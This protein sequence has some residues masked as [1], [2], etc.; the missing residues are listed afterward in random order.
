MRDLAKKWQLHKRVV[1]SGAQIITIL[2]LVLGV[3]GNHYSN[4]ANTDAISSSG[5]WMKDA[6]KADRITIQSLQVENAILRTKFDDLKERVDL[7][8]FMDRLEK[9][10]KLNL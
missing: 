3:I 1:I 2:T 9:E 7:T 10:S 8:E 6:I 4:T 5:Q